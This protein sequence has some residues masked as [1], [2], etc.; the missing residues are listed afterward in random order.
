L[1]KGL[2]YLKGYLFM[3]FWVIS[4]ALGLAQN[5]SFN[6]HKLGFQQGL[7]DGIIRCIHQD[8]YG[9]IWVG[10]VGAV[11]KYNGRSIKRYIHMQDDSLS[12]L[13]T[14]PRAMHS[15]QK[16]RFWIGFENGLMQFDFSKEQFLLTKH[17]K[18]V[19]IRSIC[20]VSEN[21]LF[22]GTHKGLY[23]YDIQMDTVFWYANSE[24]AIHQP[25]KKNKVYR[26]FYKDGIVYVGSE[27]GLLT[28]NVQTDV[29]QSTVYGNK[30]DGPIASVDIDL[31]NNIWFCSF[32]GVKLGKI[33]FKE[34]DVI[35]YNHYLE[36]GNEEQP[37]HAVESIVDFKNRVWVATV[38]QG[39]ML[40]DS[41]TGQFIKILHKENI[42]SSPSGNSYRCMFLDNTGL[43]WLGLDVEGIN[44][45]DP[46]KNL[47]ATIMPFPN[48]DGFK[49]NQV[50]RAVTS[51]NDNKLW[52]GNHDGVSSYNIENGSYQIY[53]NEK[54]GK[55]VL[56]TN[57][58][59]SIYCDEANNTWIGTS[60]GVN[61]YNYATHQM[62]FIDP[63]VLPHS[64]YNSINGDKSGN[65]WFCTNDR[66]S[67]YWYNTKENK[68]GN[69][70]THPQLKKYAGYA[71]I[72]YVFEDSKNR[73]WLST[74]RK[75]VVMFDKNNKTV[76]HFTASDTSQ[77]RLSGNLV[78]D[79]KEDK[80]GY[81]W[82][83]TFTGITALNI[84]SKQVMHFN[85]HNGLPGNMAGPLVIDD[86]DRVWAGVNGGLVLIDK[87]RKKVK[88]FTERDGLASAGFSE[89]AGINTKSDHIVLSSNSGYIYFNPDSY[90]E[91]NNTY[92]FYI[93]SCKIQDKG[94]KMLV[95]ESNHLSIDLNHDE[96]S[97]T[98]EFEALNYTN[99]Q[100]TKFA[101]Y[102]E[103]FDQHWQYTNEPQAVYT[104]VPGGSYT[105]YMKSSDTDGNWEKI[106]PKSIKFKIKTIYY[107]TT[108]FKLI[109]ALLLLALF[110]LYYQHRRNQQRQLYDLKNKAQLLEKEKATAM[111]ENLKQ[112][113]NPHFLFN[114]LTSLSGLIELDQASASRFLNQ[115]SVIYR[116]IL[117]NADA[118]TVSLREE[119][120]FVNMYVNLQKTRFSEG[121]QVFINIPQ[122]Y[123]NCKVAPV[124]LQNL[125]ENAIKH[126]VIDKYRPLKIDIYIE[127]GEYI[128]VENNLQ[129][130]VVVETSNQRGLKQFISLYK[131]L[132]HLPIIIE[133]KESF[134]KIKIPLI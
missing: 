119:L 16:G 22:V 51:A 31:E 91:E 56:Y 5:H 109:S 57:H 72:S 77:F 113:L 58:V 121:L 15:D 130:K 55:K 103:G 38:N 95:G 126:N 19:F 21:I 25:L 11:N 70:S 116:Y 134:F 23:K 100:H 34:R 10:S 97:F 27:Q 124:T 120:D 17:F 26:L 54:K 108:L 29:C 67:L 76:R 2:K 42:P 53:R 41:V 90:L 14:Q 92:P 64:F 1:R 39:V 69:I 78:V 61:R 37:F 110:Y 111:F 106:K 47:F 115:M 13:G 80:N 125:I 88:V 94:T 74:T 18:N 3:I 107:K 9:Y 98:F 132:S 65:I 24:K 93:R 112:Q 63:K 114:S 83:S 49:L 4:I 68:Y 128:V 122:E 86:K 104:N 75:G 127:N 131:F 118:E 28:L 8:K 102:L 48:K 123:H 73:L 101:Y 40:L 62:E 45:F 50:G 87:D 66:A 33:R 105:F 60:K 89:H 52:F 96:N 59:R 99:A 129:K 44:Y 84:D 36:I 6:F 71:P 32:G 85:A 20:S 79:I 117:K 35:N 12:P 30:I 46:D 133:D 43:I 7:H 81:I 82:L